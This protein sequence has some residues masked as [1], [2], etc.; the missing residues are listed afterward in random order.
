MNSN[1]N[2]L[3][4]VEV[5]A[6]Q[7]INSPPF[8]IYIN[9]LAAFW[10]GLV[11]GR[12]RTNL[13][14]FIGKKWGLGVVIP[15]EMEGPM[16]ITH[17]DSQISNL[18]WNVAPPLTAPQSH[19]HYT[20]PQNH[21]IL[22]YIKLQP[23]TFIPHVMSRQTD[24][25]A[26]NITRPYPSSSMQGCWTFLISISQLANYAKLGLHSDCFVKHFSMF[27]H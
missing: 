8:L 6:A 17:W 1:D 9:L 20:E 5:L 16:Q 7:N 4:S 13:P 21:Y 22:F 25:N 19:L 14:K 27:F 18:L 3:P 24:F 15:R 12:L 11:S 23:P 10:Q 26:Y 2:G